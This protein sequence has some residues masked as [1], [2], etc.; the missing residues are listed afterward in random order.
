[1]MPM[2]SPA[3]QMMPGGGQNPPG[4]VAGQI[5]TPNMNIHQQQ[6]HHHQQHPQ[7][8]QQQQQAQQQNQ[9]VP[10]QQQQSADGQQISLSMLMDFLLQKVYHEL[11]VLAELLPRKTDVE[12]K[13]EIFQFAAR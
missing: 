10:V 3:S 1:M 13:V 7:Q 11:V 12:R 8:Q 4:M 6:Q 5:G 9:V 2:V